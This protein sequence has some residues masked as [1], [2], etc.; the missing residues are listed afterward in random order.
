MANGRV[1]HPQPRVAAGVAVGGRPA[2][3]LHEEQREP[4]PGRP[5]VVRL[6]V[7]SEQHGV[8]GNPVVEAVDEGDEE[9]R[10]AHPLVQGLLGHVPTLAPGPSSASRRVT[11]WP[12]LPAPT[13]SIP[14]SPRTRRPTAR[15]RTSLQQRLIA[16]TA[17]RVAGRAQMQISPDQGA[18]WRCSSS[19]WAPASAV[20]VGTF[21]GY[22]ALCV[23]RALPDD[24]HAAVLRRQRGVDGDRPPRTGPRPASATRSTCASARPSTRCAPCPRA[25][26][27]DVAF[28]DADKTNYRDYVRGDRCPGCAPAG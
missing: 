8:V 17:E 13:G 2:P 4:L 20:E 1:A 27:F 3:V 19:S 23:A 22:S 25:E 14:P 9:R 21:T 11:S 12:T 18:S 7:Q 5:E 10:A 16:E 6:G 26:Q 28:V 24:G 15:P